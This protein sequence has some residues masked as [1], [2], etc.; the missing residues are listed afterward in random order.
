MFNG[1]PRGLP[2]ITGTAFDRG[3]GRLV[4]EFDQ[5]DSQLCTI[6]AFGLT[7]G[8][9]ADGYIAAAARVVVGIE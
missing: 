9:T 6:E 4:C 3:T 5:L 1:C 7:V 2:G 8:V